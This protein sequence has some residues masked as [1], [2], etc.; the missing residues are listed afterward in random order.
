MR[1][2]SE[3]GIEKESDVTQQMIAEVERLLGKSFP[4]SYKSFVLYCDEAMP[5]VNVF[6]YGD[7]EET[8]VS[9]FFK[10]TDDANYPYSIL[11]Y[12]KQQI[13]KLPKSA[14]AIARDP[15]D[16][17]ICIELDKNQQV[18]IFDPENEQTEVAA[19]SFDSFLDLLR[20]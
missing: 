15:G 2:L 8:C 11:W 12:V 14:I 9:E 4:N 5:S 3:L 18:F 10:F 7:N 13:P 1:N 19:E 20:E 17:L 6:S 16:L